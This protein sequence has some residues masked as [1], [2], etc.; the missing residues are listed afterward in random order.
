MS[1]EYIEKE[2]AITKLRDVY[3]YEY[4]TAGGDFDDYA[5]RIVPNVLHNL[6][7]ADVKP[8]V[9]GE[10]IEGVYVGEVG[11]E[12]EWHCSSCGFAV[13]SDEYPAWHFCPTCGADMREEVID[14]ER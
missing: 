4:P 12:I 7:P 13:L 1:E 14:D 9:S 8:V 3:E 5:I 6:E 10:W 11:D 2:A